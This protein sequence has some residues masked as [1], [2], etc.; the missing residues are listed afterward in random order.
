MQQPSGSQSASTGAGEAATAASWPPDLPDDRS[1]APNQMIGNYRLEQRIGAGGMGIVYRA[2]Q[3]APVQRTVAIKLVKLGIDTPH[4]VARFESERQALAVLEHPGIARVYDA[5]ITET[6]RPYFV[7]EYV[8]GQP[9]GQYCDQR[10]LTVERRLDLFTQVCHALPH[11]HYKGILHRDLKPGNILVVEI[12]GQPQVKVIDFGIAKA[13]HGPDDSSFTTQAGQF[14]GTPAYASP[15]QAAGEHLDTR[16][17][18]FSLGVILY[19]LLSG[20]LPWDC[21]SVTSAQLAEQ[22]RTREPARP[23]ARLASSGAAAAIASQHGA[24]V[25]TLARRLQGDLDRIVM[26][27]MHKDPAQRYGMAADLAEDIRRHLA[28]EPILARPPTLSYQA[29][30]FVRRNRVLVSAVGMVLAA[31]VIGAVLAVVGFVRARQALSREAAAR[32]DEQSQRQVAE[33]VSEFLRD[34]LGSVDPRRA[35]GQTVLVRDVLDRAAVDVDTRFAAQPLVAASLHTIMGETYYALGQLESS[36]AH[37][38][39]A[40]ELR[41]ATQ[42][43]DHRETLQMQKNLVGMLRELKR[44]HDAEPLAR[45]VL[46]RLRRVA[47]PDDLLT[48]LSEELLALILIDTDRAAEAQPLMQH[49]LDIKRRT[50]GPE[51]D[52][53]L[54]SMNN[55]GSV[56]SALGQLSEAAAIRRQ[57]AETRERVSGP[58]HPSTLL[59]WSNLTT[60]LMSTRQFRE[61]ETILRKIFPRSERVNGPVHPRTLLTINNLASALALQNKPDE[62]EAMFRELVARANQGLPEDHQDRY[63]SIA[64]LAVCLEQRGKLDE[65]IALYKQLYDRAHVAT[66]ISP[67]IAAMTCVPYGVTLAKARQYEQAEPPLLE[68]R[69]LLE[70]ANMSGSSKM[71]EVLTALADVCINT[72]RPEQAE[73]YRAQAARIRPASTM[74][75]SRPSS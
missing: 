14:V 19:E 12:D 58:D 30:K 11:A 9:I 41:R 57:V 70:A 21:Q 18:V 46:D 55:M 60:E 37:A 67:R 8:A 25:S 47:G 26:K 3:L 63:L 39:S 6:G 72:N 24:D 59:A 45:D 74:A 73:Q 68:A 49:A 32:K 4:V 34:M 10:Q 40:L 53:T 17:D 13:M 23:S 75:S 50:Y 43:P 22:I 38:R 54:L 62:A 27:A 51:H 42:G 1:F 44:F 65:A 7:M 2:E 56:L 36:L 48:A 5:G 35:Q 64:S 20:T 66:T 52:S 71:R 61:A 16:S 31:I 28:H 29:R 15:E 33:N 69:R